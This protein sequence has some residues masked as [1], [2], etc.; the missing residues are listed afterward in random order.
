MGRL[1]VVLVAAVFV[2]CSGPAARD[3][4]PASAAARSPGD[5]PRVPEKPVIV[6]GEH[7]GNSRPFDLNGG[8]YEV[9]WTAH[10]THPDY[11]NI[12]C[13]HGGF[14]QPTS[15]GR[16][17]DAGSGDVAGTGTTTRSGYVYNVP[18][19]RYYYSAS[20]GC[21]WSVTIISLSRSNPQPE[22]DAASNYTATQ[23]DADLRRMLAGPGNDRAAF[24]VALV[25]LGNAAAFSAAAERLNNAC[26]GQATTPVR[27][28]APEE[29]TRSEA[30]DLQTVREGRVR[31]PAAHDAALARL[32]GA[33]NALAKTAHIASEPTDCTKS[34]PERRDGVRR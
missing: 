9:R 6:S 5:A 14:I 33:L 12:Q 26:H 2:A 22:A 8:D 3:K 11:P 31:A 4:S 15:G 24:G 10:T 18:P 21:K 27:G 30:A 7:G 19:G 28:T 34:E 13:F 25:R 20:S 29:T 16:G 17:Y 1:R 23:R 32:N